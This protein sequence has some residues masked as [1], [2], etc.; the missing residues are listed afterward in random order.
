MSAADLFKDRYDVEFRLKGTW[1]MIGRHPYFVRN[2]LSDSG[3]PEDTCLF[4]NNLKDE[5]INV[6]LGRLPLNAM[7]SCPSGY[8]EGIWYSRGPD[9]NRYQGITGSSLWSVYPD[10][11]LGTDGVGNCRKVLKELS[12]Q[13]RTRRPGKRP[14]GIITR[15]VYIGT[16]GQVLV[17]GRVRGKYLGENTVKPLTEINPLTQTLLENA[18]LEIVM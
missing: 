17:R 2:V 6:Q 5:E 11:S 9:R 1:I 12:M 13:P 10:G 3:Y 14:S 8:F 7:T 18:K 4:L 16:A 15:D